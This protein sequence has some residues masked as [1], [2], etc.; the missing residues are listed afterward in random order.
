MSATLRASQSQHQ[1]WV[2]ADDRNYSSAIRNNPLGCL[3][4]LVVAGIG[5]VVLPL[6]LWIHTTINMSA[7]G[8]LLNRDGYAR[9]T[10][11]VTEYGRYLEPGA[12]PDIHTKHYFYGTV[13][14]TPETMSTRFA[15]YSPA[16][17]EAMDTLPDGR[18]AANFAVDVWYNPGMRRTLLAREQVLIPFAPDMFDAMKSR[19]R[20]YALLWLVFIGYWLALWLFVR[21]RERRLA[22]IDNQSGS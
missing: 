22:R 10:F 8:V 15:R 6:L 4:V 21:Y 1:R 9:A 3:V 19:L 13:D 18:N 11:Q 12:G 14:G 5:L 2:I 20:T 17:A 16:L 7:L